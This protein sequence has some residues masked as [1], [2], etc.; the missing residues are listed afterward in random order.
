MHRSELSEDLTAI[1]KYVKD[2]HSDK[3]GYSNIGLTD[4]VKAMEIGGYAP[5][6]NRVNKL[7]EL[8]YLVKVDSGKGKFKS[9]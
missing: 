4:I 7:I 3:L 1:L 6:K 8:G 2:N 9:I 5:I